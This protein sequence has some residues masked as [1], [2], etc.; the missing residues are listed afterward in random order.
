MLEK[1]ILK[2]KNCFEF[3]AGGK[4]DVLEIV[5]HTSPRPYTRKEKVVWVCHALTGNSNPEEWWPEMVGTGKLFDPEEYYI[6]CV[7]MLCS[8]Y[9]SS[10]PASINPDTGK[11]YLFDFPKTTVRD[12]VNANIII[13]KVLG[14][15]RIDLM[16]GP[17]I[18]GFQ[19]L[20][21]VV[22]EPE[23]TAQAVFLAT[24]TRIPPYL[25][26]FNESQR[27]ALMADPTFMRAKSVNGGKAGLSCAR[28]IALI[29]YR[30]FDSYNTTQEEKSPDTLFANRACTYQRHQGEKLINRF[31]AYSY[32]YL[33]YALDSQNIGRGR[34][35]VDE[36]LRRIKAKCAVIAIDSDGL[37]PPKFGKRVAEILKD[38]KYYEIS[39]MYGHD[40]FL[41]EYEQLTKILSPILEEMK[42]EGQNKAL[43]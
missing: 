35:G 31:D 9:G 2:L 23:V 8:P 17:S 34:G 28:S 12:I 33:T 6:V 43:V 21:W 13:R 25:T 38:G 41:L 29:S 27:M 22:M 37:F 20:E 42:N 11:S 26:A 40:G 14:I 30:S 5:Y 3:E 18:G 19:A 24:A 7:N 10:C 32:W 36:A 15:N 1:H 4:L 39:S 16:L